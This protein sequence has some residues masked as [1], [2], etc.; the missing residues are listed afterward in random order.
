M[1][2]LVK[3]FTDS[4]TAWC[5]GI[6]AL[7]FVAYLWIFLPLIPADGKSMGHDYSIHFPSMLAGYYWFLKNGFWSTPWFSPAH[8]GGVPFFA[9]LNFGYF[10]FPQWAAFAVGPITAV[11]ATFV[12]FAGLGAVG[13]HLL[14][15]RRFAVTPGAAAAAS[16]LFLFSSFFTYRMA[17]GHLASS[18]PYALTPWLAWAVLA[19]PAATAGRIESICSMA[20]PPVT[21]GLILAYMIQAGMVHVGPCAFIAVAVMLLVHGQ[22]HG[23][24][25]RP[26]ILLA[27]AVLI[28]GALSASR[29]TAAMALFGNFPRADYPLPGFPG[30]WDLLRTVFA[31]LFWRVSPADAM[32]RMQN[33]RWDL[34]A[35]EWEYGLGP[36]ALVLLAAGS[37]VAVA[38]FRKV[39][40]PLSR[41]A[42]SVPAWGAMAI[43]LALPLVL[44]WYEPHWNS[45]LKSLPY[46]GSS[47][48]LVRWFVLYIP[49]VAL[50]AGLALHRI[51]PDARWSVAGAAL[52]SAVTIAWNAT[53]DKSYYTSQDYDGA[54]VEA[55]WRDARSSGRVPAI[56]H[57][58]VLPEKSSGEPFLSSNRNDTLTLG[59][60]QLLCYHPMFG[61]RLEHLP[62]GLLRAGPALMEVAPGVLNVKNPACYLYP[63]E[64]ACAPGDHFS[65]DRRGDAERFLRYEPFPFVRSLRQRVADLTTLVA[66]ILVAAAISCS[67]FFALRRA[68]FTR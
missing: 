27:A 37:A 11:R 43:A 7:S 32:Q 58:V 18:H 8:C 53:A 67:I 20:W 9:D 6:L 63:R 56:T 45:L 61:Y 19:P 4:E 62:V 51:A 44:N 68:V 10:A 14:L 48:T 55:A 64:N 54:L 24:R 47:S 25:S 13:F 15:R 49:V 17:V 42:R 23:H 41:I 22:I 33:V 57:I 5:W 29:F 59:Y 21:G 35:H 40:Q 12:L 66:L 50:L 34:D 36:A 1:S 46:F 60:S 65:A 31:A 16:V 38:R 3:S 30:P 28:G 39:R 26:W 52:V 2:R